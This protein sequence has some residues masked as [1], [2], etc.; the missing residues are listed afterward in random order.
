MSRTVK[1]L[2]LLVSLLGAACA[3]SETP[4]P[5]EPRTEAT[6][7]TLEAQRYNRSGASL[8]PQDPDGAERFFRRALAY[9]LYFGP[10]HNNLG[11]V[12]LEKGKLYEA[13]NEFEWAR[14]LMPGH[15]DPR[16]N[17]GLTFERAARSDEALKAYA[18]ALEVYRGHVPT[19]QAM[20]RLRIKEGMKDEETRKLLR[21]LAMEGEDVSWRTWAFSQLKRLEE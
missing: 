20:A 1:A 15:P 2:L 10:A 3:S 9:D 14:K 19:K 18:S 21:D 6:R 4:G 17:L 7:N 12:Y 8:L 5:Y 11:V 13:A 16:M